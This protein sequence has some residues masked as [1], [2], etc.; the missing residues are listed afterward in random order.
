MYSLI[1]RTTARLLLPVLL[2]FSLFLLLRGHDLPGGGFIG[3]LVASAAV[4]VQMVAFGPSEV[5]TL[6][7]IR[8]QRLLGYG[9]LFALV[10]GL[11]GLLG[12]NAFLA[13]YWIEPNLPLIGPVKLGTPL[14]FDVGVYVAV[15]AVTTQI[16]LL[17][18]E[19]EEWKG[20][21]PL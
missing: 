20:F 19:E 5:R 11:P 10:A 7:P 16:I 13:S 6:F 4:I 18:A 12:G 3:G 17:V 8:Y 2:L 14:L 9:V 15:F 21:S 1:M